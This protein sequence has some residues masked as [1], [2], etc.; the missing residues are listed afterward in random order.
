M[1]ACVFTKCVQ[2]RLGPFYKNM[3]LREFRFLMG[4]ESELTLDSLRALL[5]DNEIADFDPVAEA[6]KVYDP[7]GTGYVDIDLMKKIFEKLGFEDL[8]DEDVEILVR[9]FG[10]DR[11]HCC[12]CCAAADAQNTRAA[13]WSCA[14]HW[15]PPHTGCRLKQRTATRTGES[16][17][18]IS[19]AC[20]RSQAPRRS[21]QLSRP[22]CR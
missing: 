15:P 12:H 4:D 5:M 18:T 19:E 11:L 22:W 1:R 20:L 14:V 7:E 6:F 13:T 21:G 8:S 2:K 17:W 9:W 3:P 10:C 16:A